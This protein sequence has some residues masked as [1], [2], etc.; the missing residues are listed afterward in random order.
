MTK[1]KT[2]FVLFGNDIYFCHYSDEYWFETD[3]NQLD[4]MSADMID[5]AYNYVNGKEEY[6]EDNE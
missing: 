2:P 6:E 4:V 3:Y 1:I 5:F